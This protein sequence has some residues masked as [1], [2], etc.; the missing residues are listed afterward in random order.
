MSIAVELSELADTVA[1]YRFAYLLT[2]SDDGRAH[3]VAVQP[4]LVGNHFT[5]DQPGRRSRGNAT[6][7]TAITLLWPPQDIDGYSL[8]V[9]GDALVADDAV[10]L[11]PTR[12]VLHRPAPSPK[13][14]S[15]CGSDC[16]ELPLTNAS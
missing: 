13:P 7:R 2:A 8:I 1:Q 15:A 16:V 5:I 12:A 6:A 11:T 14:D 9:D 10:S 4:R 3:A